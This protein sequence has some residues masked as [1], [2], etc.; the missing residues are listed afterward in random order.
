MIINNK[1]TTATHFAFDNCHKIYILESEK[2]K[3]E[4]VKFNY[5]ILPMVEIEETYNKS[6]CL[7]FIKNWQLTTCFVGQFETAVFEKGV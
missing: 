2:D 7:R 1:Q 4:A 3:E 5:S 6:C